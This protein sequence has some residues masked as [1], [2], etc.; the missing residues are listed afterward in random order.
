MSSEKPLLVVLGA[1]GTQGGS[2]LSYFLSLVPPPYALRGITRDPSSVKSV[3]LAS[4]GVEMVAGDFDDPSSLDATF[5]GASA[6]FSVTDFWQSFANPS[7][8]DKASASSQSIGVICRETE[9]QQ[10]RN[11]IDAAAKVTTLERLVFS[12]LPSP[13]KLS[14]GKYAHVYHFDGKAMAEEYGRSAHP[15]LWE[16][17]NV[18]YAGYYLE[19]YFGA[20]GHLFRPRINKAEDT[21]I[22]SVA[23]PLATTLLPMYSA[24]ADTGTPVQALLRAAPGKRVIGVNQ[25]L[26]LRDFARIL[27]R[28]IGKNI[29]FV[30]RNPSFD[31]GDPDVEKDYADMMGFCIDFGYDG[32]TVDESI[33]QP[34]DL[35]VSVHL[36]SVEEWCKKQGWENVL[37]VD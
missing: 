13:N 9:A 25:W 4:L 23:E 30:D 7:L 14:A 27:A 19:N 32:G 10:N 36:G 20:T 26:S 12:S 24:V 15:K 28:E 5:K 11:I 29:E 8:R 21:L 17:T 6:I 1:T 31:M 22:L 35:G 34:A 16:K 3:S 18:L 33:V 37:Q 2:V